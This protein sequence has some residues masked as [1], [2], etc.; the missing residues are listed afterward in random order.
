M[1]FCSDLYDANVKDLLVMTTLLG[2]TM[3]FSI[4]LVMTGP[5]NALSLLPGAS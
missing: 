2:R 1:I 4:L 5:K 3:T